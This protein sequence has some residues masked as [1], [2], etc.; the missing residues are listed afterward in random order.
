MDIELE[1]LKRKMG[2]EAFWKEYHR[3]YSEVSNSSDK[4]YSGKKYS[5]SSCRLQSIKDKYKDGITKEHINKM[6]EEL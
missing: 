3:L 2:D 6:L 4:R 1:K 5:N